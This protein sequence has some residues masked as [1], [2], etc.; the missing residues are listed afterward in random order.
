M[1]TLQKGFTLIELLVVIAI[2]GILSSIVLASLSSARSK[3]S[4]AAIQNTLSNMR[5]QAEIYYSN[6][7]NYGGNA[8]VS[9]ITCPTTAVASSTSG[10]LGVAVGSGGLLSLT[11]D[12]V[13][14]AGAA[15][16]TVCTVSANG[17][18]WAAAAILAS[19][20]TKAACVD[21]TGVSKTVTVT[22]P[23]L[24]TTLGAAPGNAIGTAGT[25][26]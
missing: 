21:S 5:A 12:L 13:S 19:D 25:C 15:A 17:A 10:L 4:D 22:G 26:N 16:K 2:I 20:T 11:T 14:K 18:S 23:N 3:G 7:N 1:K 9:T 24:S 6:N 8:S